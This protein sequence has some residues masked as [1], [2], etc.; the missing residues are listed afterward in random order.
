MLPRIRSER[1]AESWIATERFF[2]PTLFLSVSS[3]SPATPSMPKDTTSTA[4]STSSSVKPPARKR[5]GTGL[6]IG[7]FTAMVRN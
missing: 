4:T 6:W 1:S 2:E 7:R 5:R 3:C